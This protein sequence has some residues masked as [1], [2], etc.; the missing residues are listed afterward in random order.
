MK[1]LRKIITAALFMS[2]A[3]GVHNVG[4][5]A[6]FKDVSSTLTGLTMPFNPQCQEVILKGTLMVRT[7]QCTCDKRRVCCAALSCIL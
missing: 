2:L 1:H 7:T 5:D 6:S 3:L 4:A